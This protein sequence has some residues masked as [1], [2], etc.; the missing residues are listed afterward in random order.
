MGLQSRIR[1]SALT[2]GLVAASSVWAHHSVSGVFDSEQPFEVT[3][4][5]TDVDWI[6]PHIYLYLDATDEAGNVTTWRL[7]SL[8]TAFLRKAGISKAML[9]GDGERV[10]VTGITAHKDPNLGWIHRIT[11][12]DGHYY[13]LSES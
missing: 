3:G 7:E 6:N 12:P 9:M 10:T 11:Y 4:V 5:I 2:A 13:Q 1:I 8:P